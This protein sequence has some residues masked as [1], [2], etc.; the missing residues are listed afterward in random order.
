MAEYDGVPF[1]NIDSEEFTFAWSGEKYT[2]QP[3]ET[4]VYPTWLRDHAAKHLADKIALREGKYGNEKFHAEIAEKCKSGDV[5]VGAEEKEE[6]T[7]G[8]KIKEE[9]RELEERAAKEAETRAKR[10][11]NIAKGRA[12][13]AAKEAEKK[14][15]VKSKKKK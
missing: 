12:I 1:T 11:K 2:V 7:E 9:V 14:S 8:E 15:K 4:K 10:I 6:K 13:K 5:S 3:S